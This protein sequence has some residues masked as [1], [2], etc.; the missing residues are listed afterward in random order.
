MSYNYPPKCTFR[1]TY[2]MFLQKHGFYVPLPPPPHTYWL[3]ELNP[4]KKKKSGFTIQIY[5]YSLQFWDQNKR[6]TFLKLF[7]SPHLPFLDIY[8]CLSIF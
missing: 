1:N 5:I 2:C 4:G 3:D 6:A 8:Q 7:L